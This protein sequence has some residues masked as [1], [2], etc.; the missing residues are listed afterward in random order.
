MGSFFPS[1]MLCG[2]LGIAAAVLIRLLLIW[3]GLYRDLPVPLLFFP[4]VAASAAMLIWLLA[5]GG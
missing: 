4:V 1:W 2:V 3:S 5:F